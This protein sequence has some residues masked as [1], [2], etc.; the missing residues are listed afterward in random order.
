LY[1]G[2]EWGMM[3]AGDPDNR[4][5]MR[6]EGLSRPEQETMEHCRRLMQVRSQSMALSYGS[7]H[8]LLDQPEALI[9]SR[10]YLQED[11]WVVWNRSS[12]T[13]ETV[14]DL[15]DPIAQ[16]LRGN[17]IEG[18]ANSN[19]GLALP[20]P[21]S[22]RDRLRSRFELNLLV[23][24]GQVVHLGKGRYQIQIPPYSSAVLAHP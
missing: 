24:R 7:T 15:N 4:R 17:S 22:V 2:D 18:G 1:Y 6:F 9:M 21:R 3:G 11:V 19:R 10:R 23:G 14:V 8:F 20:L 16:R 5:M 13:L 12:K